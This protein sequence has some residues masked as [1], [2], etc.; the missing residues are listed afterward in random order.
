MLREL[1]TFIRYSQRT[2]PIQQLFAQCLIQMDG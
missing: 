2:Q 1:K